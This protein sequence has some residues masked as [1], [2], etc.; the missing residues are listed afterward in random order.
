M[1]SLRENKPL[2]IS[3]VASFAT[4][5]A[6]AAGLVPDLAAQFEIVE[7]P[8]EVWCTLMNKAAI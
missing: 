7:F 6:M 5:A 1:A 4:I 8:P 3:I 2:L